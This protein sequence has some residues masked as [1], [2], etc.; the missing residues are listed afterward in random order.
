MTMLWK[1]RQVG[2]AIWQYLNQ[3]LFD[4]VSTSVW[5][6]N[7]FWSLYKIHLLENCLRKDSGSESHY[8]Q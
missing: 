5:Q 4:P 1:V 6:P 7:R 3:P 2:E 8:T